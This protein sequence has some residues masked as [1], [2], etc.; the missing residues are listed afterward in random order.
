M[1]QKTQANWEV[2]HGIGL[3]EQARLFANYTVSW[4]NWGFLYIK[5]WNSARHMRN[6]EYF[7]HGFFEKDIFL[8][9]FVFCLSTLLNSNTKEIPYTENEK[10]R[11]SESSRKL[12]EN[13]GHPWSTYIWNIKRKSRGHSQHL[14][15]GCWADSCSHSDIAVWALVPTDLPVCCHVSSEPQLSHE[16]SEWHTFIRTV[17]RIKG[18]STVSTNTI[19]TLFTV[20]PYP[21]SYFWLVYK[22]IKYSERLLSLIHSHLESKNV[23]ISP[24]YP[25]GF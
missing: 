18:P 14:S 15:A 16:H 4:N 19:G 12:L 20:L 10:I 6:L 11:L 9:S 13:P 17:K 23:S 7:L 8:N 22:H 21:Q 1:P 2:I 24:S 3:N 25:S 5:I